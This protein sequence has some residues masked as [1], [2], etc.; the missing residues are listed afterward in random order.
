MDCYIGFFPLW[1]SVITKERLSNA[2]VER[3]FGF[4]KKYIHLGSRDLRTM[5]FIKKVRGHVIS[6]NNKISLGISKNMLASASNINK[7][8]TNLKLIK[9]ENG[10]FESS[11]LTNSGLSDEEE[12]GDGNPNNINQ[13]N[14]HKELNRVIGKTFLDVLNNNLV[15][16][17]SYYL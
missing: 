1:I 10:D 2:L 3:W 5:V 15:N 14:E 12:N 6:V 4:L 13:V 8:V 7:H 11:D 17:T 9:Y 16:D